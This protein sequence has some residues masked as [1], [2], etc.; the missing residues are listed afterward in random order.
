M[1]TSCHV[2]SSQSLPGLGGKVKGEGYQRSMCS[3]EEDEQSN[4]YDVYKAFTER[5]LLC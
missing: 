5:Q 4:L 1:T 2:A 3:A